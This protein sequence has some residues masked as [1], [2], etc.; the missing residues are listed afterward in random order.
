MANIK[1]RFAA[2]RTITDIAG[3][4][5]PASSTVELRVASEGL[6][7]QYGDSVDGDLWVDELRLL[8]DIEW[9][10]LGR[11]YYK[12]W[13]GLA[14]ELQHTRLNFGGDCLHPP[15]ST[16]A[17]MLDGGAVFQ[18]SGAPTPEDFRAD[19]R[20]Y[21]NV[22]PP[23][24][25]AKSMADEDA[26]LNRLQRD[27]KPVFTLAVTWHHRFGGR[28]SQATAFTTIH[29]RNSVEDAVQ[30]CLGNIGAA[31]ELDS[32]N[33]PPEAMIRL[34]V[35]AMMFGGD[36][37]E[38]VAPDIDRE[39]LLRRFPGGRSKGSQLLAKQQIER[40]IAECRG[41]K[42][43]SEIDLPRPIRESGESREGGGQELT[44]A[45]WRSGHMRMQACGEGLKD[46]KLIFVRPT[47][48]RPDLPI[49]VTHGYRIGR[50][51]Q[52]R[53]H[54]PPDA[55]AGL[56]AAVVGAAEVEHLARP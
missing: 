51:R 30:M 29:E 35:C 18:V 25:I 2:W 14:A 17:V 20:A 9:H 8:N 44:S 13:P 24:V 15:Y 38:L 28:V 46:R 36:R 12:I 34:G 43:G 54:N 47:L 31:A 1:P 21:R 40:E 11:P 50:P 7:R 37:H 33:V 23:G 3:Q 49:G 39:L 32:H 16:Y 27:G 10:R 52:G 41:W 48:V 56:P 6:V 19:H 45:H 26:Y 22:A 53:S 5:T 55:L 42:I 4:T